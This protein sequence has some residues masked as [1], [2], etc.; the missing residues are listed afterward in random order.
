MA[1][2][3]SSTYP[4]PRPTMRR[5]AS[6]GSGLRGRERLAIVARSGFFR[7]REPLFQPMWQGQGNPM[8][9]RQ[10]CFAA[11]RISDTDD[12][13]IQRNRGKA[14]RELLG[15]AV[16]APPGAAIHLSLARTVSIKARHGE[17]RKSRSKT[18]ESWLPHALTSRRPQ[19]NRSQKKSWQSGPERKTTLT[20]ND[21]PSPIS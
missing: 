13:R 9:T 5:R 18:G 21:F 1:P 2:R 15:R 8:R 20:T 4:I 14:G 12:A 17:P 6:T 16:H 11:F 10:R 19:E 7:K 3:H